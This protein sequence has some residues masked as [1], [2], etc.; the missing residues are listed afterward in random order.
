MFLYSVRPSVEKFANLILE[1]KNTNS[2]SFW[3]QSV[4]LFFPLHA[5]DFAS[6]VRGS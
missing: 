4:V 3:F 6:A 2:M 5:H 1:F